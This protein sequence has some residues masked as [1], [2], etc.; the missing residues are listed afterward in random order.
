MS[1][2]GV[3]LVSDVMSGR[4]S[5]QWCHEW[6]CFG[7]VMLQVG[8]PLDSDFTSGCVSVSYVMSG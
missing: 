4:V 8:V 3:F 1:L 2:M 6:V 7:S 5:G